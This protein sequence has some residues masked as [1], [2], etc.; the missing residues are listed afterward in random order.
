[1]AFLSAVLLCVVTPDFILLELRQYDQDLIG[2]F[3]QTLFDA[4]QMLVHYSLIRRNF[5]LLICLLGFSLVEKVTLSQTI[6][7]KGVSKLSKHYFIFLC[8]DLLAEDE[9]AAPF[10]YLSL[11][12][13]LEG[14]LIEKILMLLV[15]DLSLNKIIGSLETLDERVKD[16]DHA[17]TCVVF[18]M[19][20]ECGAIIFDLPAKLLVKPAVETGDRWLVFNAALE[21]ADDLGSRIFE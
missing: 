12:C 11:E 1:M 6:Q 2:P 3:L 5:R 10:A 13:G 7:M 8:F 18:L 16:I 21:L 9:V 4:R 20:E 17:H 15:G 19:D 14:V